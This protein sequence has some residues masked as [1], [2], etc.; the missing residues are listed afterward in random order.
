MV[1]KDK[2]T[3]KVKLQTLVFL[4][5]DL[6]WFFILPTHGKPKPHYTIIMLSSNVTNLPKGST[7]DSHEVHWQV[8]IGSELSLLNPITGL[9][10][11]L[12]HCHS[13]VSLVCAAFDTFKEFAPQ[14]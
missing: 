4:F 11:L 6:K 5:G 3:E 10:D 9:R 7:T 1:G 8:C 12:E 13:K 2:D 14:V